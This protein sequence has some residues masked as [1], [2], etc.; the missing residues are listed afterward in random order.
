MEQWNSYWSANSSVSKWVDTYYSKTDTISL[1][2]YSRSTAKFSG[3]TTVTVKYGAFAQSTYTTLS[4]TSESQVMLTSSLISKYVTTATYGTRWTSYLLGNATIVQPTC[5]L[6]KYV[7]ECQSSWEAWLTLIEAA[8]W[9]TPPA[10]CENYAATESRH[11]PSSCQ[12]ALS[13]YSA[14]QMSRASVFRHNNASRPYCTQAD[15]T[16]ALCTSIVGNFL[17]EVKDKNSQKDGVVN[18]IVLTT[19]TTIQESNHRSATITTEFWSW[20][21]LSSLAPGCTL[22]CQS[23][24]VNGGTVE[25]IYWLPM[26]STWIDGTY[27]AISGS[28]NKTVTAITLGTTLTSPTVYISFDSLYARD[29]CSVFDKTYSNKI[30]AI[31]DTANLNSLYGWDGDNGLGST[32]SF[33]FTDL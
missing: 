1:W 21:P 3:T 22:G 29:S 15:I 10:G 6:P 25:L 18:L 7:P 27:S 16:G 32:A 17:E 26:S 19:Y 14:A 30:I 11:Q 9:R 4:E 12:A 33:N 13:S 28:T 31:T 5:V 2:S 8:Y 23:C 24:Q 20:N